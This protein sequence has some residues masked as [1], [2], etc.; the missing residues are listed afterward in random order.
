M[1][2]AS[3][4][5][6]GDQHAERGSVAIWLMVTGLAFVLVAVT[7][8][9]AA[10]LTLAQHRAQAAA[11]L[12]ALTGAAVAWDGQT[13]ACDRA[14]AVSARAGARLVACRLEGLDVIVTV[15]VPAGLGA[16]RSAEASARAGP[17]E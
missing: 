7:L 9:L 4:S 10:G 8:I 6:R 3:A 15:E 2:G 16:R 12:A 5:G 14:A 1:A 13:A 17:V 11:D